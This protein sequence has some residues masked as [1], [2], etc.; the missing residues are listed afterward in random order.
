M[1]RTPEQSDFATL[2]AQHL[3]LADAPLLLEGGTGIGK[4][5]A[6]L[7]ALIA[8]GQRVAVVLPTHPLID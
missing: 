6:Y 1:F 8:S 5:R 2:I 4:T 7:S 3:R